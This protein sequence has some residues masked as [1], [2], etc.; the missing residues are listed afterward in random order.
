MPPLEC[1]EDLA[2]RIR[3]FLTA[4]DEECAA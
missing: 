3:V 2:A 4:L 1:P